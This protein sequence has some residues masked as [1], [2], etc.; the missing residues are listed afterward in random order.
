VYEWYQYGCTNKDFKW[1]FA[2]EFYWKLQLGVE[3]LFIQQFGEWA[4]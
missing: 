2:N 4:I 1:Y 3:Q